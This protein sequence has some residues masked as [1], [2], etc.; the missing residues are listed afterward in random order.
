MNLILKTLTGETF[1]FEFEPSDTMEK[2]K[3]KIPDSVGIP[4][5]D[6]R[7]TYASK[8]LDDCHILSD[9]DI[10]YG[11]TIYVVRWM[12]DIDEATRT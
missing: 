1:T 10:Q 8:P 5:K 4:P 2:V 7:F 12:P 11:A 3:V 6:R 9:C